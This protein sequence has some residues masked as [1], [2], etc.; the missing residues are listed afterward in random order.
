M[1]AI[2]TILLL[3]FILSSKTVFSQNDFFGEIGLDPKMLVRGPYENADSA[4]DLLVKFGIKKPQ[5]EYNVYGEFFKATRFYSY[6][7][8]AMYPYTLIHENETKIEIA[9]GADIG[10]ISRP[11]YKVTRPTF[12][13]NAEL[14]LQ[15]EDHFHIKYLAN[16][17]YR[18][19][20]REIYN[21]PE[22]FRYSG[23]FMIG[24]QFTL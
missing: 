17:R 2:S 23:Y 19:D 15:I 9:A 7:L 14:R 24:Y 10:L 8:G 4:L 20:L 12:S 6:G 11:E 3:F 22:T 18:S 21:S 1:R 13:L 5:F 16:Y